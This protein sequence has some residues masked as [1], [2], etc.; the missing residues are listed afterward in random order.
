M[1][2]KES[3]EVTEFERTYKACMVKE[4]NELAWLL[5]ESE[6][7]SREKEVVIPV[8]DSPDRE[9]SLMKGRNE[10]LEA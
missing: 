2:V 1:L 10:V 3:E 9:L 7:A 5:G 4:C 6:Q 8:F